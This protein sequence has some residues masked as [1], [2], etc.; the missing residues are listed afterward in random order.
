MEHN[1]DINWD[2][3]INNFIEVFVWVNMR[4]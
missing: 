4:G 1:M 3:C 2:H